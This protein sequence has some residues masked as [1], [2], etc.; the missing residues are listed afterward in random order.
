M[1]TFT[2]TELRYSDDRKGPWQLYVYALDR[3]GYEVKRWF[4]KDVKYT[5][6]EISVID[7]FEIASIASIVQ[8]KEVRVCDG[9]DELVYHAKGS[10]VL[11]GESFW[12]D[13][14]KETK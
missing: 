9:G 6:E 8:G 5:D 13:V 2:L 4:A 14:L 12:R 1:G 11:Y 3:K 7:A 10:K